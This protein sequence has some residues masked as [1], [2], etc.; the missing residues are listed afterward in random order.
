M[1]DDFFLIIMRMET[2]DCKSNRNH[3]RYDI[4]KTIRSTF[5][6]L[7][8]ETIQI[9]TYKKNINIHSEKLTH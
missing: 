9:N 8:G 1:I 5:Y 6:K 7:K 2:R 4:S 3:G